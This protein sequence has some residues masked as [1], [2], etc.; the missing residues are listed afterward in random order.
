LGQKILYAD[1]S[2]EDE[3][4]LIRPV[5]WESQKKNESWKLKST[6]HF[7]ERT[8]KLLHLDKWSF[9]HWKVVVIPTRFIWII[10]LFDGAFEYGGISKVWG[11]PGIDAALLCLEFCNFCIVI[12]L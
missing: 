11:Y 8:H 1:R 9:V 10:I 4:L 12:Y 7:M 2:L 3:L 5:L 6:F